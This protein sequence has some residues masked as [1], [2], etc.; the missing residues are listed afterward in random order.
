MNN[1]LSHIG[2]IE[3]QV[4][5]KFYSNFEIQSNVNWTQL[6]SK[7]KGINSSYF[8]KIREKIKQYDV[9]LSLNG[10][11]SFYKRKNIE[12]EGRLMGVDLKI[13]TAN[14]EDAESILNVYQKVAI[15]EE[16]INKKLFSETENFSKKGGIFQM[17]DD[18]IEE[19]ITSDDHAVFLATTKDGRGNEQLLGVL[20]SR[21][22]T[23]DFDKSI[24]SFNK[25]GLS[26]D[27]IEKFKCDWDN[28]KI[29]GVQDIVIDPDLRRKLKI[30]N[31]YMLLEYKLAE[32]LNKLN[33]KHVIF[34]IYEITGAHHNND[35]YEIDL[36]NGRS[37]HIHEKVGCKK[38]GKYKKTKTVGDEWKIDVTSHLYTI[39]NLDEKIAKFGPYLKRLE[40]VNS[41]IKQS[42]QYINKIVFSFKTLFK[43]FLD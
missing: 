15:N 8:A 24:C 19:I 10:E 14:I 11:F 26:K 3:N 28:N 16:T 33:Y 32:V 30:K 27:I 17:L 23:K 38:I 20:I 2:N 42:F 29:A 43:K 13:R 39:M 25:L 7:N 40:I 4:N 41:S 34:E 18:E 35:F 9:Y 31:L 6:S 12:K 37:M 22:D 36:P 5:K 21:L 1:A